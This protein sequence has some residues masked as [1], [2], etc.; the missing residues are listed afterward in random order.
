MD[1]VAD[2]REL[3][4]QG[5]FVQAANRLAS[6]SSSRVD[7]AT[8]LLKAQLH[9]ITGDLTNAESGASKLLRS[10]VLNESQQAAC[11]AVLSRV[12][13]GVGE[14]EGELQHLQRALSLAERAG[15]SDA[16]GWMQLRMVAL[17]ADRTGSDSCRSLMSSARRNVSCAGNP[18]LTAA[19][20]MIV[21]D[22]DGKH[23]LLAKSQRHVRL[24][25]SLLSRYPN[26]W[27]EGWAES[28]LLALAI[29]QCDI[30]AAL[31]HGRRAL[32]L[33]R[34]SGATSV[35]RSALAEHGATALPDG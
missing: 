20:H 29:V 11:E 21:A 12:A 1:I 23:G 22:V 16:L 14:H 3:F 26:V 34:E 17:T 13:A 15:D 31:E 4:R 7:A 28:T 27:L 33:G 9:E 32:A 8:T 5:R 25:Q 18:N 2:A 35:I 30:P 19:L 10:R 24:A 6:L